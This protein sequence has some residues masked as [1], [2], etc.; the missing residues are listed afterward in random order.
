MTIKKRLQILATFLV[1]VII[2]AKAFNYNFV[3]EARASDKTWEDMTIYCH[4]LFGRAVSTKFKATFH[5]QKREY[6]NG[7]YRQHW[8][9][10]NFKI[11]NMNGVWVKSHA[12]CD[13]KPSSK[14]G[15]KYDVVLL[16]IG[17]STIIDNRSYMGR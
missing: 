8:S 6:T 13:L 17:S 5:K 10:E 2:I 15:Q 11:K 16:K 14:S 9:P 1:A 4:L 7:E 12:F 3:T